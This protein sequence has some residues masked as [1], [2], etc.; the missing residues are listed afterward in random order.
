MEFG[1]CTAIANASIALE[2]KVD[3]VEENVQNF[4]L[5]EKPESEFAATVA[6]VKASPL[7]VVAS[8]CFLPATLKCTGP[9]ID[10]PR[11]L[12]YAESA[13]SRAKAVGMDIIVFGSGGA[14]QIPDGFSKATA[15][16]QFVDLLK[17][18]APLAQ[19]NSVI[20]VV[21]PLNRG[22]CN[23]INTVVEGAEVTKAVDHPNVRLLADLFHMLR[24]EESP[25]EIL[26]VGS[27]LAHTH[28]AEREIRSAPGVKGDNFRPFLKNLKKV[29]YNRRMAI[30]CNWAKD[31]KT[32]ALP[33]VV[34]L[35]KQ[36]AES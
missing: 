3:F 14:R 17:Q 4:L 16:Q 5:P 11:L 29:G 24:N 28:V 19:K 23:F 31:I 32:E 30:E 8:N 25:E 1:I 20:I 6:K 27:L 36:W 26:A 13:F 35:K 7:P 18:M 15:Q 2:A 21:E 10:T 22:E 34:E 9:V 33:A 12:K